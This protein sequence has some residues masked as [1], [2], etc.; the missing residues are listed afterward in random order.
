M[1]EF[2]LIVIGAGSG[3]V[4]AARMA[5][6]LGARVAI[7]EQAA[8]G[9]TCVNVGC[10]PKKLFYYGAHHAES[11]SWAE[12]FGWRSTAAFDWSVL[13]DNTAIEV[14]RLN[15]I[16]QHL[17]EQ[18]GAQLIRGVASI[19][20]PG[21]ISVAGRSH[22]TDH[23]LIATGGWPWVP[24]FPGHELAITS[25]EL[26]SLKR[27][28]ESALIVGGGYIAVEFAG[29]LHRLGVNIRLSYRGEL[30]LR[31]FDED[32]R[33]HLAAQMRSHMMVSFNSEVMRIERQGTQRC[34]YFADG[35]RERFDLVLYA[36]GRR[37]RLAGLG[38]QA[39][40]VAMTDGGRIA[41]DENFGTSVPR[42]Y[43]LGDITPGPELT[44]VAI[45]EAMVFAY[46]LFGGEQRRMDYRDIPTA[47]FSQPSI[48]T[49]GLTEAEARERYRAVSIHKTSFRHLKHS[50]GSADQKTLMKL[51]VNTTSKKVVGVHM[52]G[53]DAGEIIQGIAIAIKAGARVDDFT[54]TIGIHPTAAEEFVSLAR[55]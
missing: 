38:L 40:G 32:I 45:A 31:G 21:F 47:V 35:E 34:V 10:I 50:L 8:L 48:G 17:L 22:R 26:F 9:G 36:T 3:G 13:R 1:P 53:E 18:S 27:L 25:N 19:E 33:T 6:N 49:V 14:G 46:N 2:D 23:I 44:P 42:I 54:A 39:L 15:G 7:V 37:P 52:V 30:F 5:G 20:E 43:A 12:D 41:V 11:L 4:R 55:T 29:I 16:Y 51:I 24:K 28:P